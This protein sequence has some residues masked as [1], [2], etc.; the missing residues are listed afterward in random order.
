MDYAAQAGSAKLVGNL[1]NMNQ[2][3]AENAIYANVRFKVPVS[4][5]SAGNTQYS[6]G[7]N[8]VDFANIAEQAFTATK[9]PV[10]D[11][12]FSVMK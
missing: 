4:T 10:W 3:V 9:F 6:F 12:A 11:V 5:L 1:S 2:D 8:D 7:V